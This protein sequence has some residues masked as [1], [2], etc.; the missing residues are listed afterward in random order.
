MWFYI[1]GLKWISCLLNV[2]LFLLELLSHYLPIIKTHILIIFT[3]NGNHLF[4]WPCR[5]RAIF[6]FALDIW[7]CDPLCFETCFS[8]AGHYHEGV[9]AKGPCPW[10][11]HAGL[12]DPV[13]DQAADRS[14]VRDHRPPDGGER[15]PCRQ[16]CL[17][18]FEKHCQIQDARKSVPVSEQIL[19]MQIML[20]I[21]RGLPSLFHGLWRSSISCN[22]ATKILTPKFG[23][24]SY[25]SSKAMRLD[26]FHG[27]LHPM[28]A[29]F[30]N[31]S[32]TVSVNSV[33]FVF[34]PSNTDDFLI[35]TATEFF[36]LKGDNFP[37][38]I[39]MKGKLFAIG[40]I[41]Q[42]LEVW[43]DAHNP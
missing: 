5:N 17:L 22:V 14:S 41:L 6:A 20:S 39:M 38:E 10:D 23:H 1:K 42:L 25:Y 30:L 27:T 26:W 37:T 19:F 34:S 16:L 3:L 2:L 43:H 35:G 28:A 4:K 40:R 21:T 7:M 24:L 9:P 11:T 15:P 12:H 32:W 31:A 33:C 13:W 36:M 18:I 29:E 8:G